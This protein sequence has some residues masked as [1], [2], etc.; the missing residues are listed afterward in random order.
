M[1]KMKQKESRNCK[2][3]MC[4]NKRSRKSW[5]YNEWDEMPTCIQESTISTPTRRCI[6]QVRNC[7]WQLLHTFLDIKRIQTAIW[8]IWK[9]DQP[10]STA[11]SNIKSL[12]LMVTIIIMTIHDAKSNSH[13]EYSVWSPEILVDIWCMYE[14]PA[15]IIL[16]LLRW[17][18]LWYMHRVIT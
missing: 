2:Q 8:W 7:K 6:D 12:V 13:F 10:T 11:S 9:K 5:V 15:I 1:L 4:S 14:L 16:C 3:I 17:Q 18:H